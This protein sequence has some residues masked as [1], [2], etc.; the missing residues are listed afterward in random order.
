[1]VVHSGIAIMAR[2]WR[3]PAKKI[4]RRRSNPSS[5][6]GIKNYTRLKP[7]LSVRTQA[8]LLSK[9]LRK[10]FTMFVE[11]FAGGL[12]ITI[13]KFGMRGSISVIDVPA[14]LA[15]RHDGT[16]EGE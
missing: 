14:V 9:S 12:A 8:I 4:D 5:S 10:V 16:G 7:G 13:V 3:E 15:R 6:I 1:M 2:R 11:P